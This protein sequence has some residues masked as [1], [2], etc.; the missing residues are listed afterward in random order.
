MGG[1]HLN[2]SR[3]RFGFSVLVL[4]LLTVQVGFAQRNKLPKHVPPGEL[5]N[6]LLAPELAR[7]LV[8]PVSW[9]AGK[10]ESDKFLFLNDDASAREFIEAFW[11]KHADIKATFEKRKAE[12]DKSF[13][14]GATLGHRTDRG[15]V[16]VVFGPPKE[17]EYEKQ[18]NSWD[19]DIL[20]WRYPRDAEPGLNGKKPARIYR[21]SKEGDKTTFYER[22]PKAEARRKFEDRREYRPPRPYEPR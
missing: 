4:A 10:E 12:A 2:R 15:I 14:E 20:V 7:F 17:E 1:L 6:P 16:Y 9:I 11:T 18:R 21:F 19:P 3:F 22:D 13:R 5:T 8:G